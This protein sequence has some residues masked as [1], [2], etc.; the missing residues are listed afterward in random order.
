MLVYSPNMKKVISYRTR[1]LI[2]MLNTISNLTLVSATSIFLKEK[3]MLYIRR[4][5]LCL[6]VFKLIRNK[7]KLKK[8]CELHTSNWKE[9][10]G[11]F[12]YFFFPFIPFHIIKLTLS[13]LSSS[14]KLKSVQFT[15]PN[16]YIYMFLFLIYIIYKILKLIK[17]WDFM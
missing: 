15:N 8:K 7:R 2:S 1:R 3:A 4:F 6:F 12:K 11:K 17:G 5:T 10:R 13:N 16:N 9:I 14:K